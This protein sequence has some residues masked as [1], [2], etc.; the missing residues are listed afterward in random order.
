[1][2]DILPTDVTNKNYLATNDFRFQIRRTPHL[3]YF[4][5]G[6]NLP[7]ISQSPIEIHFPMNKFNVT[8]KKL[9]YET[10]SL[11]FKVDEDL[12]NYIEIHDWLIGLTSPQDTRQYR[13]WLRQRD[14]N[15]LQ[16]IETYQ[17]NGFS[18]GT[19][20]ITTNAMNVNFEIEFIDMFPI[21]L[22]GID[23]TTTQF[24]Q[25][26]ARVTFAYDYFRF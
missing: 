1:M 12:K 7:S 15:R 24:D 6:V 22:D 4:C 23:F 16:K 18:D 11:T 2:A 17:R 19:L 21:G 13:E 10:L 26:T 9:Q 25:P 20:F 3:N 5:Q 14:S 8:G